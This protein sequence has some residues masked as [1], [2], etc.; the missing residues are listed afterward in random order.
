MTI[1]VPVTPF[2]PSSNWSKESPFRTVAFSSTSFYFP[3]AARSLA[4]TAS[5]LL[6]ASECFVSTGV[7]VVMRVVVAVVEV[8]RGC[9]CL[10]YFFKCS[11]PAALFAIKRIS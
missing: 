5:A 6:S 10:L 3:S 2:S 9:L 1:S 11:R 7:A 8:A 4:S